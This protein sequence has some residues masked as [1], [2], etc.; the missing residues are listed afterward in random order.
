MPDEKPTDRSEK[1]ESD[2]DQLEHHIDDA[3]AKAADRKGDVEGELAEEPEGDQDA[4]GGD[5]PVGAA[6]D[7]TDEGDASEDE[8]GEGDASEDEAGG[9]DTE[10][11]DGREP[12]EVANPT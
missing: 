4:I 10:E 9:D 6:E 11:D 3:K 2:L 12:A 5:D 7:D 8:A 1:M